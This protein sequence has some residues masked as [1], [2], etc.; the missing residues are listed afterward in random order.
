MD[1]SGRSFCNSTWA[2]HGLDFYVPYAVPYFDSAY[3]LF[4]NSIL[5]QL[6]FTRTHG[7]AQMCLVLYQ[8][9]E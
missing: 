2:S 5:D 3:L 9:S 4:N 8:D 1:T 6:Q 7:R